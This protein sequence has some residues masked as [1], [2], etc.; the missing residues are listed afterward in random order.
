M[1][2]LR[3]PTV[4]VKKDDTSR[5]RTIVAKFQATTKK[6][7]VVGNGRKFKERNIYIKKI[8][9]KKQWLSGRRS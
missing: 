8:F 2:A 6:K 1:F 4:L 9:R 5:P 3:G 7:Q